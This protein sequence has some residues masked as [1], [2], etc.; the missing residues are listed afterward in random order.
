MTAERTESQ[1]FF[2]MLW[3]C[4][5]CDTKG[6]LGKSQRH[7][8]ECGAPQDPSKR[9]FPKE[10]EAKRIDGHK[11]EGSD[12]KCPNCDTP[13]GA[14]GKNCTH[15]G[16]PLDGSKLVAKVVQAAP[17]KK[18]RPWWVMAIVIGVLLLIVILVYRS[19]RTKEAT[20][21][22]TEHRWERGVTAER[23][24][25]QNGES[26]EE[27]VP[28][29]AKR[30][31]CRAAKHPT[32]TVQ[33]GEDCTEVK[34]DKGDGTFEVVKKCK[35]RMVAADAKLCT[36]VV[37]RWKPIDPVVTKGTGM[38]PVDPA[39]K[40]LPPAEAPSTINATRRREKIAKYTLVFGKQSCDVSEAV[41]RKYADGQ[42]VKLKVRAASGAIVC[43]DLE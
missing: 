18:K 13:Q 22:V 42:D 5:H 16:A 30:V 10:G 26:L 33:D 20:M 28:A 32:K 25:E 35:P 6:L 19:C 37:E 9:Y 21:K 23:F 36:Y 34:E 39:E 4:E 31:T 14:A 1:G 3:D 2:E 29:D 40:D 24:G 43:G 11:Y 38:T 17:P 27:E 8:A 41:W 12:R 7:C 15:C